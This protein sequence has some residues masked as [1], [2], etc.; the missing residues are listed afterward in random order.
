VEAVAKKSRSTAV[1]S[2]QSDYEMGQR[3][4]NEKTMINF[5]KKKGIQGYLRIPVSDDNINQYSK[6]MFEV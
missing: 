5:Y 4:M 2:V 1:L 6:D 3:G